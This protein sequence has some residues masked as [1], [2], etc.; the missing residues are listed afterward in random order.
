MEN[1]KLEDKKII[2]SKQDRKKIDE[3]K[4]KIEKYNSS[5]NLE[6]L[7][8]SVLFLKNQE[9]IDFYDDLRNSNSTYEQVVTQAIHIEFLLKIIVSKKLNLELNEFENNS[10]YDLINIVYLLGLIYESETIELHN[11]R[12]LRN[13]LA[14]DLLFSL[15]RSSAQ[16]QYEDIGKGIVYIMRLQERFNRI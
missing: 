6:R 12:K 1:Y 8:E 7:Q 10:F 16:E 13:K 2:L 15:D 4:C 5:N 14:H 11:Y 9:L 3:L